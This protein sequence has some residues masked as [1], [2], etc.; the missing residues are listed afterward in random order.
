MPFDLIE[1]PWIP[2]SRDNV[3]S[4]VSLRSAFADAARIQSLAPAFP[5][6]SPA[7]VRQVLLPVVLR[8]LGP[9]RSGQEWAIRF[10]AGAFTSSEIGM[11]DAYLD[12]H[13]DRFDL[14]HDTHP[15]AQAGGLATNGPAK[16]IA[17]L[18]P[19]IASGNN[20][21]LFSSHTEADEVALSPA[22]AAAWLLHALCWDTAAIKTGAVDDPKAKA[23][24][25]TGNP[26]GPL[27]QLGVVMPVGRTLFE[28]IM[29]N[30]PIISGGDIGVPSWERAPVT[31]EWT[32]RRADGLLDLLT[33]PARRIRLFPAEPVP[34]DGSGSG[35][36]RVNRVIVAAGD[37]LAATPEY[38]PHTAWRIDPK[39]KAGQPP[40]RPRRHVAGKAAWRGLDALLALR[41]ITVDDGMYATSALMDQLGELFVDGDLPPDYPLRIETYGVVYGNQSAVV[42]DVIV[43]RL[44]LPIAALTA[45]RPT[46]AVV[47]EVARQAEELSH[48]LNNLS[49]DLRRARGGDPLPW[50]K[51]Q[52]PGDLLIHAVDFRIRKLF[53]E[54]RDVGDDDRVEELRLRWEIAARQDTWRIAGPLLNTNA[55]TAFGG[56]SKDD[57][58]YRQA[59]AEHHFATRVSSILSR[60]TE[61]RK[62]SA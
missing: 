19:T 36:C 10:S 13:R 28:T 47:L 3:P 16:S 49:A 55:P 27:G 22:E 21:P 46:R 38:E 26:T 50:D 45:A 17:L 37:R 43:D 11:I 34:G 56:R 48:A 7:L 6:Q 44:P 9:P 61:A 35:E 54:L 4:L 53:T 57:K 58:T 15:F 5:T 25:T 29:L 24:K 18:I 42:D 31:G 2:V 51:G 23:G 62:E 41:G 60:A 33:W 12:K 32:E 20:V 39:P 30:S 52:R 8:A 14:F 59:T 1:Q 40:R